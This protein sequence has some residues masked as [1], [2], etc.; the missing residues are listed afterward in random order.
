MRFY[1]Q[2]LLYEQDN[3]SL[4][5]NRQ[6]LPALVQKPIFDPIPET[7][8]QL[9]QPGD[10]KDPWGNFYRYR[11]PSPHG[12]PFDVWSVGPDGLS[13]TVDDIGSW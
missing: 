7:W 5:T 4:P 6:G 1:V 2:L 13:G 11:T 3:K 8:T 9:S 12:K 10:L